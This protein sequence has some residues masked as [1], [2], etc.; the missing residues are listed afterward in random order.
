MLPI[1]DDTSAKGRGA[2]RSSCARG[3]S[4]GERLRSL[5]GDSYGS[6]GRHRLRLEPLGYAWYRVV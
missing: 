6:A 3:A 2:A 1:K 4:G 5:F